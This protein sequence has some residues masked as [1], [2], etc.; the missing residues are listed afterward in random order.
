VPDDFSQLFTHHSTSHMLAASP[1]DFL[2]KFFHH[3][4]IPVGNNG[5][6]V[7]GNPKIP[8]PIFV[9]ASMAMFASGIFTHRYQPA[10]TD[11]L[12]SRWKPSDIANLGCHRPGTHQSKAGQH[13]EPFY[14][15]G[16]F[17]LFFDGFL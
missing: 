9:F 7:K 11:E 16:K 1:G 12:F 15:F 2:I 8:V 6:L 3:R 17:Y 10:V 4:I 5:R 13:L 14:F